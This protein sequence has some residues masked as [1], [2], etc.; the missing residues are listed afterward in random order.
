M[1]NVSY[2]S[3]RCFHFRNLRLTSR[4]RTNHFFARE[5]I[6][7]S[8][9]IRKKSQKK[10]KVIFNTYRRCRMCD[11]FQQSLPEVQVRGKLEVGFENSE[12]CGWWLQ[13]V[14]CVGAQL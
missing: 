13:A 4:L 14:C 3:Q 6:K 12:C 5:F 11:T 7:R 10:S 2:P 1:K 9:G 8:Q